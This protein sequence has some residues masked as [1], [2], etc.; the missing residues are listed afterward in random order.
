[1]P[2]KR[3]CKFIFRLRRGALGKPTRVL[4]AFAKTR[5]LQPGES[6]TLTLSFRWNALLRWMIAGLPD[7]QHCY[8]MEPGLYRL[9][10]GNSVR[11]LQPLPVDGEAGYSQKALRVL[12]CH[13]QV[14]ARRCLSYV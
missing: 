12:S 4:V 11:D 5:L 14:L 10:L 3:W 9:L 8:V 6:E 1:M 7:I 2:G 13:Q